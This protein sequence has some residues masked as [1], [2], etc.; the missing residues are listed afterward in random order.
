MAGYMLSKMN[1]ED[2]IGKH[3]YELR[4]SELY[5]YEK[6]EDQEHSEL[7]LLDV[8]ASIVNNSSSIKLKN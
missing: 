1:K 7:I 5:G 6:R 3:W 4:G 2:K 8:S